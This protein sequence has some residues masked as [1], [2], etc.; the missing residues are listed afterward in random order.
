MMGE[1]ARRWAAKD[2]APESGNGIEDLASDGDPNDVSEPSAILHGRRPQ[3]DTR[4]A[5]AGTAPRHGIEGRPTTASIDHAI[6]GRAAR[7]YAASIRR[8]AR[9]S[10]TISVDPAWNILLDL[11][12]SQSEGRSLSVTAACLG[13]GSSVTTGLRYLGLLETAGLVERLPDPVDRRRTYVG[14][15]DEGRTAVVALLSGDDG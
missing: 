9:L 4:A 15:T 14:L 2:R 7:A 1:D 12:I 11:L 3:L 13:S 10:S 5:A 6:V 8:T